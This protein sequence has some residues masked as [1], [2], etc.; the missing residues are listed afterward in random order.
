M[1]E[2]GEGGE[3]GRGQ[4]GGIITAA[5]AWGRGVRGGKEEKR[6]RRKKKR[7]EEKGRRKRRGKEEEGRSKGEEDRFE[8][9]NLADLQN[10]TSITSSACV[11]FLFG[12]RFS[13]FCQFSIIF[14]GKLGEIGVQWE[15]RE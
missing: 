15:K 12:V 14:L 11:I 5:G 10:V 9:N 3:G 2:G 7:L 4:E 1:G 6:N 8:T 13:I